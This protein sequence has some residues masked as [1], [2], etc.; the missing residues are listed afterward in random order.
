[1]SG[2]PAIRVRTARLDDH[3][4]LVVLFD[5]LDEFHRQARPDVFQPFAGPARTREQVERWLGGPGSTLLVAEQEGDVVGL[6]VLVTRPP[7]AFAGAIPHKVVE[8]ENIVVRVDRRGCGIG[9]LL[10]D[11][12]LAWSR[13][14]EASHVGVAV[15]AF[16]RDARR[17]Y[18]AFGF[19]PSI[20][21]LV[22][23]T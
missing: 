11:A 19:A 16:N 1:M 15:H 6:A 2:R 17:F 20:D 18:E 8:L 23:R 3:D 14:Q 5:E 4:A 22:L 21:R 12:A 13:G 9:R 7:P 10:L